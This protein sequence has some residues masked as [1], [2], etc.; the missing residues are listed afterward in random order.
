MLPRSTVNS[1]GTPGGYAFRQIF[2]PQFAAKGFEALLRPAPFQEAGPNGKPIDFCFIFLYVQVHSFAA[3]INIVASSI[4]QL[5]LM[6]EAVPGT[7]Q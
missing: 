7:N 2:D 1:S 5:R 6:K 3:I 4:C